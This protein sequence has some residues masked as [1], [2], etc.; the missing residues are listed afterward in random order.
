MRGKSLAATEYDIKFVGIYV[1]CLRCLICNVCSHL[2]TCSCPNYQRDGN[3]FKHVHAVVVQKDLRHR[4]PTLTVE[5]RKAAAMRVHALRNL[6]SKQDNIE[7]TMPNSD[8]DYAHHAEQLQPERDAESSGKQLEDAMAF[9]LG[10]LNLH[11][12][13]EKVKLL[14]K[15]GG[16]LAKGTRTL[17]CAPQEYFPKRAK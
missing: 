11:S 15:Y 5:D 10:K 13:E 7:V 6:G 8:H 9:F 16:E 3:I 12:E 2:I 14:Y 17:R 1:S 4:F